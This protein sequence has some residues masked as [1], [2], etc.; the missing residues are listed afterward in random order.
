M[1]PENKDID[2]YLD[3]SKIIFHL[4]KNVFVSD[5]FLRM[6]PLKGI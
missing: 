1:E 6:V 2:T 3:F 4:E 5:W